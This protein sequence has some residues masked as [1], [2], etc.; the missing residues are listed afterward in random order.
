MN[1][2]VL[3]VGKLPA[4]LLR[5]ML[6]PF[7]RES[8][9]LLLP[10]SVGEDAGVIGIGDGA[11]VVATDPITLTGRDIGGHA[12][13]INANDVAVLGARPRWFLAVFLLPVGTTESD[14]SGMFESMR[15]AL[16]TLDILLV[17]GHTE[18]T[19]AVVQ[20]VI[21]G[22]M[23][24]FR[25]DG[26]FVRTG[27][28]RA[29]D[30]VLQIGSAPVEGAAV[31]ANEMGDVMRDVAPNVLAAAKAAIRDPGISVVAP[32]L[33]AATLGATAMHDPTEGGLSAGLHEMAEASGLAL[34]VHRSA[35]LWYAPGIALC[36][37]VGADPWG[38]LASGT[39]L[40]AFPETGVGDVRRALEADGHVVA[41]I[42]RA[43]AGAGVTFD[44]GAPMLRYEQDELSRILLA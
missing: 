10:P 44:D 24:G 27:G 30:V 11:L 42:A 16:D 32:A 3:P 18:V 43:E 29:S 13:L 9:E 25:E 33:R 17:G 35:A 26:T 23:L 40:A 31:L 2:P 14:V 19:S 28:V 15:E 41:I 21:T 37:A 12:V 38:M 6:A 8:A 22:Q 34:Q 36:D 39:L 4:V 5:R 7:Q 20:P 1:D